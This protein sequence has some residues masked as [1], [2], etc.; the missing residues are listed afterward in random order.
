MQL[1]LFV[2]DKL[3]LRIKWPKHLAIPPDT[4]TRHTCDQKS[5]LCCNDRRTNLF[6]A[7]TKQTFKAIDHNFAPKSNSEKCRSLDHVVYA[8]AWPYRHP[9]HQ[10][11]EK[12]KTFPNK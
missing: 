12:Y 6:A 11:Q 8:P 9:V 1:K 7:K 4:V 3:F 5:F 10:T 2:F